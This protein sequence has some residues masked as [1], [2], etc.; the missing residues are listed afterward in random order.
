ME[1]IFI[2]LGGSLGALARYS[3]NIKIQ[4][5][6]GGLF[7]LGTF[8]VNMLGSL[9]IG[10]LFLVFSSMKLSS[11]WQS[12]SML[13]F[14]GAFT[15]YSTFA[16]EIVLLIQDKKFYTAFKYAF[17]SIVLGLALVFSVIMFLA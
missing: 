14:L 8:I 16:Y 12:A 10:V 17:A 15:T 2:G 3:I 9:I 1:F 6:W 11:I 5:K 4:Q 13:G 7:P